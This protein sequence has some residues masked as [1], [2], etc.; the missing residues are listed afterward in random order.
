VSGRSV[1]PAIGVQVRFQG[2]W[3]RIFAVN[4]LSPHEQICDRMCE[5]CRAHVV[6]RYEKYATLQRA[7]KFLLTVQLPWCEIGSRVA[8][9]EYP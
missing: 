5:R 4:G 7:T 9:G 3:R 1:A 2:S 6:M 8:A